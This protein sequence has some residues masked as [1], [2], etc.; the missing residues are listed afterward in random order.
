MG[1]RAGRAQCHGPDA[2]GNPPLREIIGRQSPRSF[3]A[4]TRAGRAHM[5]D[6]GTRPAG[7]APGGRSA[8]TV[9]SSEPIETSNLIQEETRWRFPE[10]WSATTAGAA[11]MTA[12]RSLDPA[13]AEFAIPGSSRVTMRSRGSRR[14]SRR[15]VFVVRTELF[16]IFAP[17]I[18]LPPSNRRRPHDRRSTSDRKRPPR[19]DHRG[20]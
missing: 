8:T 14:S 12:A 19:A 20:P 5:S 2:A 16:I 13:R 11:S 1:E 18:K 17:L 3:R 9:A 6:Q 10:T 15:S 4:V 7:P